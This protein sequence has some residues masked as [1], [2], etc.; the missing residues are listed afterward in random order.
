MKIRDQQGGVLLEVLIA[1]V[2]M[3]F[4]LTLVVQSLVQAYRG[5]LKTDQ[6]LVGLIVGQNK[7][8]EVLHD[9]A[10]LKEGNFDPPFE[11]YRYDIESR[12]LLAKLVNHKLQIFFGNT[13]D[14]KEFLEVSLYQMHHEDEVHE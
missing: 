6:L 8:V 13:D 1:V 4:S 14:S 9:D 11:Q 5:I 2:V 7:L 10:L 3:A 12:R